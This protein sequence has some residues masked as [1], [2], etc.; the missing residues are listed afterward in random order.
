MA[1]VDTIYGEFQDA[2]TCLREAGQ[3]S[4]QVMLEANLR[5]TLL[6]SAAS[7]FEVQL[8]KE[9]KGFTEEITSGNDLIKAL[10][11][12]KAISR[13]YHTWF[14]WDK[15]NANKFFSLFGPTFKDHMVAVQANDPQVTE[16]IK[17]FLTIGNSR[18]LLV[19]SDYASY[20]IDRTPDEIYALYQ[21][22][23]RFVAAVGEELRACSANNAAKAP[24]VAN[25][26]PGG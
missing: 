3:I 8:T 21:A 22:A 2:V 4:L 13:Q 7:Y 16:W 24:A 10:V 26:L 23:N 6:L 19:H 25:E 20:Y 5:K 1:V 15:P 9:I 18:N 17:A 12:Q 11:E 14:D